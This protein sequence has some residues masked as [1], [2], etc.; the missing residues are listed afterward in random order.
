MILG[1]KA[2]GNDA[3][4]VDLPVTNYQKSLLNGTVVTEGHALHILLALKFAATHVTVSRA[5]RTIMES[6][7]VIYDRIRERFGLAVCE[8][9]DSLFVELDALEA[10][11]DRVDGL[12]GLFRKL[13]DL[14]GS[15]GTYGMHGVSSLAADAVMVCRHALDRDGLLTQAEIRR[16]RE[17]FTTIREQLR[18]DPSVRQ[19]NDGDSSSHFS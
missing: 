15:S 6:W 10:A 5:L 12:A 18:A 8:W 14:S 9:V 16:L 13:H 4:L 1:R 11:P 2:D 3:K 7:D 19:S 17:L